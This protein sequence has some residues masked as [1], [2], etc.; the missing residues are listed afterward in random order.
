MY[1][2]YDSMHNV[3]KSLERERERKWWEVHKTSCQEKCSWHVVG[4]DLDLISQLVGGVKW[5]SL[6]VNLS[7]LSV[8]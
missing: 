3:Y 1:T 2:V 5:Y 7:L 8:V 6:S 4:S